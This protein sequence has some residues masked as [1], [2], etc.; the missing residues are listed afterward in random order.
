MKLLTII[1]IGALSSVSYAGVPTEKAKAFMEKQNICSLAIGMTAYPDSSGNT[2]EDTVFCVTYLTIDR[3]TIN[4]KH[5]CGLAEYR[6]SE[7]ELRAETATI[8]EDTKCNNGGFEIL[9]KK[10]ASCR[11]GTVKCVLVSGPS[12]MSRPIFLSASEAKYK[13]WFFKERELLKAQ[14]E[15]PSQVSSPK[16]KGPKK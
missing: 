3:G 7:G 1:F 10:S 16:K 11:D 2:V 13:D 8:A 6:M 4:E 12:P 15:K 14:N 9:L 5:G